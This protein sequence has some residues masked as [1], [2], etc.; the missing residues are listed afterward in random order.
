MRRYKEFSED[1][2]CECM[3]MKLLFLVTSVCVA[4]VY[5]RCMSERQWSCYL[6][7]LLFCPSWSCTIICCIN[8]FTSICKNLSNLLEFH[9]NRQ[10]IE[11]EAQGIENLLL[12]TQI[13][14]ASSCIVKWIYWYKIPSSDDLLPDHFRVLL[15]CKENSGRSVSSLQFYVLITPYH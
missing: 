14:W 8:T 10:C 2:S 3:W 9:R 1:L 12:K 6:H 13:T 11:D 5:K 4:Q 15:R 7:Q